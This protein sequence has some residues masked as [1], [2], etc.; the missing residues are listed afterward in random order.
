MTFSGHAEDVPQRLAEADIFTLPSESEAF[1]NAVLEAMA[2]GLPIVASAV[3]GIREVVH[4]ERTGLLVPPRDPHALADAICRLIADP[5]QAQAL[6]SSGRA[7]VAERYSF[8]RMVASIEQL[9]TDELTRRAP[10]RAVQSQFAS[11]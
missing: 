4:H 11:L 7:F 2:A 5:P 1:P 9:Y 6:A 8:D 3:G 10:E